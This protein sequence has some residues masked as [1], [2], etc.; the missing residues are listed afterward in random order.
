M[1]DWLL[2]H[3]WFTDRLADALWHSLWIGGLLAIA[4][5]VV[6]KL[7][8]RSSATGRYWTYCTAM[9]CIGLVLPVT[10]MW[11]PD[12]SNSDSAVSA[13]S[14]EQPADADLATSPGVPGAGPSTQV[15]QTSMDANESQS[16][17]GARAHVERE[18][19]SPPA[20]VFWEIAA[21]WIGEWRQHGHTISVVYTLGL[22]LMLVRLLVA[23]GRGAIYRSTAEPV[24]EES[25]L[26]LL[27]RAATRIGL[28][29]KPRFTSTRQLGVPC[30]S[31]LLRPTL[32]FPAAAL[33][34]LTPDVLELLLLHELAHLKRKDH[35]VLTGQLI[36][37]TV[38]FYHPAVWLLSRLIRV[39]REHCCDDIVLASKANP[40]DYADALLST[41]ELWREFGSTAPLAT[42]LAAVGPRRSKLR[43]RL[44][45]ILGTTHSTPMLV[46]SWPLALL[47]LLFVTTAIA[48]TYAGNT[49]EP[50]AAPAIGETES[51]PSPALAVPL[52]TPPAAVPSETVQ[53][54]EIEPAV[55]PG[56][57]LA[58]GRRRRI[59]AGTTML[60]H[61]DDTAE[62]QK[63]IAASGH[64][65]HFEHD[66]KTTFVE[67][68]EIFG[69]RYGTP[70]PPRD[71]FFLYLLDENF[72]IV[73]EVKFPYS[74]IPRGKL[75]WRTLR[76][77]SVEVPQSFYVALAFNPHRTKGIYLGLD[78]SVDE[79]HS[80]TGLPDDGFEKRSE[81]SDWMVRVHVTDKPSRREGVRTL[82]S[83][84]KPS[85]R[86]DPFEGAIE[87]LY[88]EGP[89]SGKQSYGGSGPALELALSDA[90]P[91][92]TDLANVQLTGVRIYG[93]RYGSGF[94]PD[95]AKVHI[96]ILDDQ[97][98]T[99]WRH[100]AAYSLF[101]YKPKWVDIAFKTPVSIAEFVSAGQTLTI[102]VDPEAT[103]RKG[104]YFHYTEQSGEQ[105][106]SKGFVPGKRFFDVE[107]RDWMIR[108]YFTVEET[109]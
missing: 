58:Q 82:A 1:T 52:E 72:E 22:G 60:S 59:P 73:G 66:G 75:N 43:F 87:V 93:S 64:A 23:F 49:P 95:R 46:H 85:R 61:V 57:R 77:P 15:S 91:D 30:V 71:D 44:E 98:V 47:G 89:S 109:D 92:G 67:A 102:G 53:P 54:N 27:D 3:P 97:A 26:R 38:C 20:P 55:A 14:L 83:R 10:S 41:A 19:A 80:W 4:A 17:A 32:L 105:A 16:V 88:D 90:L 106:H 8:F 48:T 29:Y 42:V 34:G 7:A 24:V 21:E 76:T 39:E 9:L 101:G 63:S 81:A 28:T 36:V 51:Q 35:W 2:K 70:R 5:L 31:G 11:L 78:D 84:K 12:S 65:V 37:E 68:I 74:L 96:A 25:Q 62:A 99:V 104:L 69:S 94:N 100:D 6:A 86:R 108:T 56:D 50:L 40:M 33:S 103:G 13:S 45:R 79:S 18:P 107:N